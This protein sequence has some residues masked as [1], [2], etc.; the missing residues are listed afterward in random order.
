MAFLQIG[1]QENE[2]SI[3]KFSLLTN[4]IS[5]S[6]T[7]SADHSSSVGCFSHSTKSRVDKWFELRIVG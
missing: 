1:L 5:L 4:P 6:P 3:N 7:T 2:K